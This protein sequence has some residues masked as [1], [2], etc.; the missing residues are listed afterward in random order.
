MAEMGLHHQQ[1][2]FT[3][4]QCNEACYP[5]LVAKYHLPE[6]EGK[7]LEARNHDGGWRSGTPGD[8][9][10]AMR[11]IFAKIPRPYNPFG[12]AV[13]FKGV[14]FFGHAPVELPGEL[15]PPVNQA[16]VPAVPCPS[17]ALVSNGVFARCSLAAMLIDV[18]GDDGVL[19]D[20][21]P[22]VEAMARHFPGMKHEVTLLQAMEA[23]EEAAWRQRELAAQPLLQEIS[24]RLALAQRHVICDQL[25]LGRQRGEGDCGSC[26]L[27]KSIRK[28]FCKRGFTYIDCQNQY[29]RLSYPLRGGNTLQV[30]LDFTPLG[31]VLSTRLSISGFGYE[32]QLGA[33]EEP[34]GQSGSP[35]D[36][37]LW[38]YAPHD[39]AETDEYARLVCEAILDI[40]PL[41][42][43]VC[44]LYPPFPR[45]P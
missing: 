16:I 17:V 25:P 31:R 11:E 36:G 19:L 24:S 23:G 10:Q 45:L 27:I 5:R 6:I 42:E 40:V 29:Y 13:M 18:T 38:L 8:Y 35:V 14:D 41:A 37:M 28:S 43:A 22:Y 39:Q 3:M 34:A 4:A 20:D 44:D 32:H 7:R 15:R 12:L 1:L 9:T 26:S 33:V 21:S 2:L 30:C